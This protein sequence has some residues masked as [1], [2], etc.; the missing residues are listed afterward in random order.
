LN[1]LLIGKTGQLGGSILR[2][3][4]SHRI[5][6]PDR[7]ELD[8][9]S[10]KSCDRAIVKYRPDVVINTAAFHNLPQCEVEPHHAFEVNC[11]AVRDLARIC[12]EAKILLVTFSTDYVF[13]GKQSMPYRE[14]DRTRPIQ[15][16]GISRLAGELAALATAP[17]HTVVIRTCGLYGL[18][19]AKSKGGNFVDK[20]ISEAHTNHELEMGCDQVVS[21]T[22]SGDLAQAL[23]KLI[24]HPQLVPG[25]YHLVNEGECTWFE[26]TKVI[27]EQMGLDVIVHPVDRGGMSG[28]M[29]RPIYS[30]L[31]NTKARALGITLSHWRDALQHYLTEKYGDKLER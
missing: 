26:F 11:L 8:I 16:Y 23:L 4:T 10:K 25:I 27:Y 24:E 12:K 7:T 19:G 20:R 18:S 30:A 14:D 29:S 6:S 3:E 21:P 2:V 31:A 17:Q 22:Y 28:E 9:K 15:M 5:Y 13:G 1:I